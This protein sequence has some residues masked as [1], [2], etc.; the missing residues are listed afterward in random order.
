MRDRR[1]R[2][3]TLSVRLKM[4]LNVVFSWMESGYGEGKRSD[5]YGPAPI[6]DCVVQ[7]ESSTTPVSSY[8]VRN[9][10]VQ[11]MKLRLKTATT[12]SCVSLPKIVPSFIE[13]KQIPLD[14]IHSELVDDV[15]LDAKVL[16]REFTNG[17]NEK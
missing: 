1:I 9:D 6:R 7:K 12:V 8:S 11:A 4:L 13:K 15:S 17:C 16:I 5:A 14:P 3:Q 10:I 2:S